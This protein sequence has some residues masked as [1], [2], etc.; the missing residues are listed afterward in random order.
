M[1]PT[2]FANYIKQRA[3]MQQQ[4]QIQQHAQQPNAPAISPPMRPFGDNFYAP[5]NNFAFRN[6]G[7][8]SGFTMDTLN[9]FSTFVD[10]GASQFLNQSAI[11]PLSPVGVPQTKGNADKHFSENFSFSLN[12]P[13]SSSPY[14]HLLLAN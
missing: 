8:D 13:G 12:S 5:Q 10:D 7:A 6:G 3:Q 11:G 14:Q 2:E 9:R 1:S 4:M